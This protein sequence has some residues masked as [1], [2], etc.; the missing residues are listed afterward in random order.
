VPAATYAAR[1]DAAL[2][3]F[4]DAE[5]VERFQSAISAMREAAAMAQRYEDA[6]TYREGLRALERTVSALRVIR[7]SARMEISVI[8]EG[9]SAGL[10]VH[11]TQYGYLVDTLRLDPEDITT[12]RWCYLL[13]LN[14]RSVLA[15]RSGACADDELTERQIRD[16]FLIHDYRV[17]HSPLEI[18]RERSDQALIQAVVLAV[19]DAFSLLPLRRGGPSIVL[20]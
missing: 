19:S 10:A 7:R 11:V 16:I 5:S 17:Q 3:A 9:S 6:I 12:G 2:A 15:S 4:T 14:L 13:R 1:V 20:R 8:I 18:V